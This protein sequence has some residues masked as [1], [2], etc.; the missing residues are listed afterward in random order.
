M[1][2]HE[3][4]G[5]AHLSKHTR[6]SAD[7]CADYLPHRDAFNRSPRTAHASATWDDNMQSGASAESVYPAIRM[8]ARVYL[9]H[10]DKPRSLAL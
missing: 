7:L 3:R 2:V 10:T 9:I 5:G 8:E 6:H 1:R 4:T